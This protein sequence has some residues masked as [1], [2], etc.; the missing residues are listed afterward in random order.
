MIG[1]LETHG[2]E[3]TAAR[4]EGLER[5]PRRSVDYRGTTLEEIDLPGALARAPELCLVDELAHTNAPGVEHP[6]RF[7]DVADLLDAGID[8]FSTVNVQHLESAQRPGRRR[9]RACACARPC[10]TTC[11]RS[12]DEVVLIDLTPEALITRLREGKVYPADRVPAALNGFFKV[13]N[14]QAL[15]EVALRQVAEEVESRGLARETV[16]AREERLFGAADPRRSPSG[17]SR[18]SALDERDRARSC[19]AAWRSSQRLDAELDVLVVRDPRASRRRPSASSSRRCGG[20]PRC[21]A[22]TCSSR[23]A[24]TCRPSPRASRAS[25]GRRTC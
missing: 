12:A 18:S 16:I 25:A 7:E 13:E 14:L 6:K 22:R 9:S 24:T 2:R 23:R 11:S 5:V 1:L 10:P 8:V 20:S 21:S 15:R 19:A 4:A 17:C 3:E